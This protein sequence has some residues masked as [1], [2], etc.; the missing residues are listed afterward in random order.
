[1]NKILLL[2]LL[3]WNDPGGRFFA[4]PLSTWVS[5]IVKLKVIVYEKD[6]HGQDGN[7][8]NVIVRLFFATNSKS[9]GQFAGKDNR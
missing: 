4:L 8:S 5:P 7:V 9:A 6:K 2:R 1:M 3:P